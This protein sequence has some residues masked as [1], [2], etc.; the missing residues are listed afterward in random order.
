M[1]VWCRPSNNRASHLTKSM[2][3]LKKSYEIRINKVLF[4]R[5][6]SVFEPR[7]HRVAPVGEWDGAHCSRQTCKMK[8]TERNSKRNLHGV[9]H[10]N[11]HLFSCVCTARS[12]ARTQRETHSYSFRPAVCTESTS[13]YPPGWS[14]MLTTPTR[15]RCACALVLT[16]FV[17]ICFTIS[18]IR[19]A[20]CTKPIWQ[21]SSTC[22]V[23]C[24][25]W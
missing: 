16:Q 22:F 1:L 17:K 8:R 12:P 3:A 13:T 25:D 6:L 2:C 24:V 14:L 4:Y 15:V 9:L 21:I 11:K 23:E 19:L 20:K 7:L 10:F 18:F 5:N